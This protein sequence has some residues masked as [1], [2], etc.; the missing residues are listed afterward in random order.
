[1]AITINGNGT[2]TGVSVGGLPD[3][4][5]DTDML[6]ASAVTD[7]KANPSLGKIVKTSYASTPTF[8][9]TTSTSYVDITN[10][11]VNHTPLSASNTLHVVAHIQ[12][13][14][15]E[16]GTYAGDIGLRI[17][18]DSS[19]ISAIELR[20]KDYGQSG[21]RN[22][23][24]GIIDAQVSAGGTSPITFKCQMKMIAGNLV[25][26]NPGNEGGG[27]DSDQSSITIF[28]IAS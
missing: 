18:K 16:I 2:L 20:S 28:E 15:I 7:A 25:S 4:I 11:T 1:M 26:I 9:D 12:N 8:T 23:T 24:T 14:V 22:C 27:T 3:G 10:L 17:L 6:A 21:M 19:E 5:V 13:L